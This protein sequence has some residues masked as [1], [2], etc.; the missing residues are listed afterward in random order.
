MDVD[1]VKWILGTSVLARE[2]L[3]GSL[4][5]ILGDKTGHINTSLKNI[6]FLQD[7][8][9]A[10]MA[11]MQN[12]RIG[13]EITMTYSANSYSR[14]KEGSKGYILSQKDKEISV[15][16]YYQTGLGNPNKSDTYAVDKDKACK[17]RFYD[18]FTKLKDYGSVA[19]GIIDQA[20]RDINI[21]D[22][23]SS[24][25]EKLI[26]KDKVYLINDDALLEELMQDSLYS[27]RICLEG[28]RKYLRGI[29]V[30]N[31]LE[32][33][34]GF[35]GKTVYKL[36]GKDIEKVLQK[37]DYPDSEY[38]LSRLAQAEAS[39]D[40]AE[41][42]IIEEAKKVNANYVLINQKH[43]FSSEDRILTT[44]IEGLPFVILGKQEIENL[45]NKPSLEEDVVTA[46]KNLIPS[47]MIK[48]NYT[49]FAKL[50]PQEF[51]KFF[52]SIEN[53]EQK[54][55]IIESLM[56]TDYDNKEVIAWLDENE[57]DLVREVGLKTV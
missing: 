34:V 40:L 35:S 9:N 13:E 25:I 30:V 36:H 15:N 22:L 46:I 3:V 4:E 39:Q 29:G 28:A 12:F 32:T 21:I 33:L 23:C 7:A 50:Y 31:I 48:S 8:K 19:E 42:S 37:R 6:D 43:I 16:F 26:D 5:R 11:S 2:R 49:C 45:L 1:K 57:S 54:R 56:K 41:L 20:I 17:T 51:I 53:T 52:S 27:K 44:A 55:I 18:L 38:E 24:D 14:T 47:E 10:A